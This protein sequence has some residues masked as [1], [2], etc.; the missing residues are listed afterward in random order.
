MIYR[1]VDNSMVIVTVY[2]DHKELLFRALN[3]KVT[4]ARDVTVTFDVLNGLYKVLKA[5]TAAKAA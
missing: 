5:A 1:L 4:L 3:T 2:N